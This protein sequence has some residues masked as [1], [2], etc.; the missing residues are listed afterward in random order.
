[1]SSTFHVS[2]E[3]GPALVYCHT[4]RGSVTAVD[5]QAP[6]D[7]RERAVCRALLIHAL[8]LLDASEPARAIN[9]A[10]R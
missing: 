10:D 3:I 7:P 8:A 2:S 9:G 6:S 4:D 5:R 1:M